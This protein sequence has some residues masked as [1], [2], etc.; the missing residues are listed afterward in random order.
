MSNPCQFCG[1][2]RCVPTERNSLGVEIQEF[3]SDDGW[4]STPQ[5]FPT[6]CKADAALKQISQDGVERRVYSRL[7][8]PE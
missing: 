6:Y 2:L 8:H 5:L 4:V 3:K 7:D 1:G